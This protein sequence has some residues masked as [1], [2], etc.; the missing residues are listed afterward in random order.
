MKEKIAKLWARIPSAIKEAIKEGLRVGALGI[1]SYV[2]TSGVITFFVEAVL[3]AHV[4]P[5]TRLYV[6]GLLTA[7]LRSVD[8]WLHE[9]GKAIED[10]TGN[11]SKL[12]GGITRF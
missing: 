8:K 3:G 6:S 5:T 7:G 2:L 12:T 9:T 1:V 10:K 11:D 4:D